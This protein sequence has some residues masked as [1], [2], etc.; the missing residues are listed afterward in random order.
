M[1]HDP[2]SRLLLALDVAVVVAVCTRARVGTID[3]PV[4]VALAGAIVVG[5]LMV[6]TGH[7][8]SDVTFGTW[9]GLILCGGAWAVES[10]ARRRRGG[11]A[12]DPATDGSFLLNLPWFCGGAVVGA[13]AGA[14]LYAVLLVAGMMVGKHAA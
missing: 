3:R 5:I 12:P 13:V 11:A 10:R 2:V 8:A 7:H 14:A 4:R 6:V 1:F 9:N